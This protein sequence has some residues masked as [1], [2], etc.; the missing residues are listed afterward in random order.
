M[1]RDGC[2]ASAPDRGRVRISGWCRTVD[3]DNVALP[4]G[5]RVEDKDLE[6]PVNEMLAW[7]RLADRRQR[8]ARHLRAASSSGSP[9]PAPSSGPELLVADETTGNVDPENGDEPS[10]VR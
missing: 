9:S 4:S 2:R 10:I 1:P 7:R 8:A 5:R 6:T 3:F